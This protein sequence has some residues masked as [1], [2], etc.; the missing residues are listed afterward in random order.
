M[1]TVNRD[2]PGLEAGLTSTSPSPGY[3]VATAVDMGFLEPLLP[4]AFFTG[5]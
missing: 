3:T 5:W 4:G 2:P 1:Q